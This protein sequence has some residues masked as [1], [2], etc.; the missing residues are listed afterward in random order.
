MESHIGFIDIRLMQTEFIVTDG[1]FHETKKEIEFRTCEPD[2]LK[3]FYDDGSSFS[4]D[5]MNRT[6]DLF[7]CIDDPHS[8]KL[9]GNALSQ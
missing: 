1:E 5:A 7:Y 2:D 8:W 9:K 4:V 6:L 3:W